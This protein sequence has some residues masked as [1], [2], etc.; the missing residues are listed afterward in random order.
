MWALLPIG[1]FSQ[2]ENSVRF[3]LNKNFY[4]VA[5]DY[6]YYQEF[7]SSWFSLSTVTCFY[8]S[9]KNLSH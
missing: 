8:T 3:L 1:V 2:P 4:E 5:L 7:D 6:V 9:K